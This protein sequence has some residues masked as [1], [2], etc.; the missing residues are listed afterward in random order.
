MQDVAI[1][2]DRQLIVSCAKDGR[3]LI[4]SV[5]SASISLTLERHDSAVS[6]CAISCDNWFVV[7]GGKDG[8]L[9]V[10]GL[11]NPHHDDMEKI[12]GQR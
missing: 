12:L 6:C 10:W 7:S 5:E 8:S 3:L 2:D 11:R 1:S 4:W 9:R